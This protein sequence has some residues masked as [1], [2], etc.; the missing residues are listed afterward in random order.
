MMRRCALVRASAAAAVTR[1]VLFFG[2]LVV[3]LGGHRARFRVAH[4]NAAQRNRRG[5]RRTSKIDVLTAI[6]DVA[7]QKIDVA[8]M[9]RDGARLGAG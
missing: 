3:P 9:R 4:W 8:T 7:Q 5:M 2:Q 1:P 6:F